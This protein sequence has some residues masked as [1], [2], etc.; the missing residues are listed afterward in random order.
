VLNSNI[1]F[2][3]EGENTMPDLRLKLTVYNNYFET[4]CHGWGHNAKDVTVINN[5][6]REGFFYND[7]DTM[8][9]SINNIFHAGGDA[10]YGRNNI[11]TDLGWWQMSRYGWSLQKGEID[12]SE[13][14]INDIFVDIENGDVHLKEGSPAI[15]TGM[16]PIKYLPVNMFPEYNFFQDLYGNKRPRGKTWDV[17]VHEYDNGEYEGGSQCRIGESA[18]TVYPNP[19]QDFIGISYPEDCSVKIYSMTGSLV[20]Q[21]NN[22]NINLASVSPGVFIVKVITEEGTC[23]VKVVKK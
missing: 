12:W 16:N 7:N 10:D 22:K 9:I 18:V 23:S 6:C 14:D 4:S 15:D 11:Y 19:A 13:N 3:F 2:T 1:S 20:Y 21:D 8:T 17:G 5:V